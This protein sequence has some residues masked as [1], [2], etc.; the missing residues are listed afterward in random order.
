MLGDADVSEGARIWLRDDLLLRADLLKGQ[1]TGFF[2]DQQWNVK[3][4][5]DLMP[6]ANLSGS[7]KVL[8]I[9]CYVGQWSAHVAQMGQR[10]GKPVEVT[11]VDSSAQALALAERNVREQGAHAVAVEADALKGLGDLKPDSFDIVIC[12]PPAFVKKKADL[13]PGLRAY[14][15]LNRDALRTL[16]KGGLYVAASCSGLVRSGDWSRVLAESSL[17]A[18]RS[19]KQI[20]LGGHGPDHPV[21]PEFPEGEYLKCVI[22]RADTPI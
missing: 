1:K 21:R 15:K 7:L 14:V 19:L 3:L 18:G 5:R 20:A 6:T 8:D 2:L 22:G 9:C 12:D 11:L 16:K 10:L 17:K 13:E 4:L